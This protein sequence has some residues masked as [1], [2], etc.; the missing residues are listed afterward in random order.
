MNW[1]IPL[2][3]VTLAFMLLLLAFLEA[4]V[5][6]RQRADWKPDL[7]SS[8][9]LVGAMFSILNLLLAFTFSLA[10]NRH[11]QRR[12]Q[13]VVESNAIRAL[14]RSLRL[15]ED[16][17][18]GQVVASLHAD[19]NGRLAFVRARL[20]Q[21]V[22]MTGLLASQRE[23]LNDK[24]TLVTAG[25]S[26]AGLQGQ[27]M[28]GATSV[29]DAGTTMESIAAAHVPPRVVLLLG[30]FSTVYMVALGIALGERTRELKSL[31]VFLV[32]VL[33]LALFSIVDL[34]SSHWGSIRID[35]RPL[36]V[37]VRATAPGR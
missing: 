22:E 9:H 27:L 25:L 35:D 36:V 18:R 14:N 13:M 23:A 37:A 6:F 21:Q 11:D 7:A 5:R 10:L 15:L 29:L 2:W 34:D 3:A 4:G 24:I 26:K 8:L 30:V 33:S 1:E 32:V 12:S 19:A 20:P 31:L 17:T 28:A 16:P